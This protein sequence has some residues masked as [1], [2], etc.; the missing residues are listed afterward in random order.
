MG[1]ASIG[2]EY[3]DD[4]I[5]RVLLVRQLRR[6]HFLHKT[7]QSGDRTANLVTRPKW[8]IAFPQQNHSKGRSHCKPGDVNQSGRSQF[9]RKAIPKGA[10][11][12]E[13]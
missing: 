2:S 8:A 5:R 13:I 3:S 11:A 4:S 12:S 1:W 10:I 9:L 7:I 6:S